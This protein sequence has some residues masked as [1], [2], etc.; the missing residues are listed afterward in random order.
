MVS[1]LATLTLAIPFVSVETDIVYSKV[2]GVELKLDLY[3][4]NLDADTNE[5]LPGVVLIH[6]GAWISGKKED[7]NDLAKAICDA[8]FVVANIQYR[9]APKHKFPAF[10]HDAQT[11]V[12][13]L[14][15][16]S[17]KF[18]VDPN[19]IGSCGASAGGH[20]ALILG[21]RDTMDP[22][23][24]EFA[25]VSSRVKAVFNI[26]GP[27]DLSQDFPKSADA[28]FMSV[29]GKKRE[30]AGAEIKDGSPVTHVSKD[31]APVFTLHGTDDPL[32]P[33]IQSDRLKKALDASGVPNELLVIQ[34]M[35]HGI[36][37]ADPKQV[38]GLQKG[39]AWL[40]RWLSPSGRN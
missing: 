24:Q 8:G 15:S 37:Q 6:G 22:K 39:I 21:L 9:L 19:R 28:I 5:A 26:F 14:K 36:D 31:D 7:M 17:A 34:G 2:A 13:F 30:E 12:R 18:G 38:D 29:I 10:L 25:G 32:V 16:N 3:R 40:K 1:L 27:T 4:P 23:P 20:M 11:A 35:K 33:V